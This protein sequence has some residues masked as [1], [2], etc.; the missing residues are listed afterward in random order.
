MKLLSFLR[1]RPKLR[2]E[3]IEAPDIAKALVLA[4]ENAPRMKKIV[5][6]YEIVEGEDT[7]HGVIANS[8]MTLAEMN[9]LLDIGKEWIVNA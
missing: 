1:R 6:I 4:F 8:E 3:K 7:T 5:V 9:L 2:V